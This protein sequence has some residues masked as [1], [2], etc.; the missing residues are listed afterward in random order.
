M[1]ELC[2][3][4]TDCGPLKCENNLCASAANSSRNQLKDAV[5]LPHSITINS[6][7]STEFHNNNQN[8]NNNMQN[9][10]DSANSPNDQT[11]TKK[12]N[13]EKC[14]ITIILTLYNNFYLS[15]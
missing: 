10:S 11:A 2:I 14:L 4:N 7:N 9:Q 6:I 1:D 13:S 15:W 3:V 5:E 8:N 12:C